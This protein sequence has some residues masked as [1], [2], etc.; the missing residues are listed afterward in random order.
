MH[1][2]AE[3]LACYKKQVYFCIRFREILEADK[4]EFFERFKIN[5]QVV[6]EAG[7]L[8]IKVYRTFG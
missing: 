8:Y 7:V 3:K 4:I 5:R 6:Q 2:L 1:F